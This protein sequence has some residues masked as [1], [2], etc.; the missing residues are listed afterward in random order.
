ARGVSAA[1]RTLGKGGGTAIPGLVAERIDPGLISKFTATLERGSVVIAGTNGKTTTSKMVADILEASGAAVVHNRSGSNLVQGVAATCAQ[2]SSFFGTPRGDA[3]VI[4]ADEAAFP[5]IVRRVRPTVVLL[6]NLYRDQLDR[7]GELKT[8]MTLWRPALEA[9]PAT[10]TVVV[11]ADDPALVGLTT[12]L[13][14]KVVRFGMSGLEQRLDELPHAA[15]SITCPLCGAA[16]S[17][18][19]LY[20]S[21]LGEWRC[22]ACGL[23]RPDLDVSG[24]DLALSGADGLE[25]TVGTDGPTSRYVCGMPGIY[26]AY[27]LLAAVAVTR[28]LGVDDET[29]RRTLET[30]R[31]AFGRIERISYLDRQLTIALV[32]NP[33]GFNEVL[34]MLT[35]PGKLTAPVLIAIND[36]DADGRDVSWLWDVDFELL[37]GDGPP[38]MTAG[39]RGTDMANR[40]KYAGVDQSRIVSLG[41]SLSDALTGFIDSVPVGESAWILPTYTAMLALRRDLVARGAVQDYWKPEDGRSS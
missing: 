30:F 31:S 25:L 29:A 16:L 39:I 28:A 34:R 21:H 26:N 11:N 5:E 3:G 15:D 6:N 37:A 27:N 22:D 33:V 7:Y 32:K 40:L 1:S 38:I 12:G 4:E 19:A 17:Y 18:D 14:A 13:T 10:S 9:L 36:L 20:L 41:D 35:L 8:I 24:C 2:N 23:R